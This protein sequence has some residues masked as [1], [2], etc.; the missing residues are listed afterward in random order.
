MREAPFDPNDEEQEP[1]EKLDAEFVIDYDDDPVDIRN[2]SEADDMDDSDDY[3]DDEARRIDNADLDNVVDE[4]V[5]L[6]NGRDLDG[7][8]ELLAPDVSFELVGGSSREDVIDGLNDLFLR[9]PTLLTTRADLGSEP[10]V[11]VWTFDDE[12]DRFDQFGFLIFEMSDTTET[13][14]ERVSYAEELDDAEE[15]VVETPDRSD[16]PEWEEWS[17]LAED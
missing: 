16:L 1:A 8:A 13:M 2:E 12:A 9:Y 6:M 15:L 7:M 10:M 14:I 17:E 11:A 5:D 4:F 3:W